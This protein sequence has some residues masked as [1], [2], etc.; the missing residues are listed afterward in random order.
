MV[1]L[2]EANFRGTG[3]LP[4][5]RVHKLI[6]KS[7]N[8]D[9]LNTLTGLGWEGQLMASIVLGVSNDGK[10]VDHGEFFMRGRMSEDTIVVEASKIWEGASKDVLLRFA[11]LEAGLFSFANGSLQSDYLPG[12]AVKFSVSR[13]G[14]VVLP[15]E[16]EQFNVGDCCFRCFAYLDKSSNSRKGPAMKFMVLMYN[17][18]VEGLAELS[19]RSQ[20]SFWPGI[21]ILEGNS[22]FYPRAEPGKWGAPIVPYLNVSQRAEVIDTLPIAAELLF[23]I[24]EVMRTARMPVACGSRAGVLKKTAEAMA[25]EPP[26]EIEPAVVWPEVVRPSHNTGKLTIRINFTTV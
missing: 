6:T 1:I 22:G 10:R 4:P 2:D 21:K 26:M 12:D 11:P 15:A 13:N 16:W 8:Q 5:N 3:E 20:S 19:D 25:T 9:L 7:M 24:S 23:A 18:T 17:S 14:Q